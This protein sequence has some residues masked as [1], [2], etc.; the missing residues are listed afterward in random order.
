MN[1]KIVPYLVIIL[2]STIVFSQTDINQKLEQLDLKTAGIEDIIKLF[3]EPQ[4]YS[5][6][7]QPL[8]KDELPDVYLAAYPNGLIFL[9]NNGKISEI[10]HEGPTGYRYKN[11]LEVGSSLETALEVLGQP[12]QTLTGQKNKYT[13][14]VLYKDIDG[15]KGS[16]YYQRSEQNIR[17]FFRNYKVAALYITNP[18]KNNSGGFKRGQT[19]SKVDH[20]DD[21]RWKDLSKI[22]TLEKD[23]VRSLRF[24]QDTVWPKQEVGT[25]T[26]D[27]FAD[28]VLHAAM[29]PG[30]GVRKLHKM[31][32]T[33][34]GV[35]VAIID[36]PTYLIHSEFAGKIVEYYDTG[37][38]TDESS[39]HGPSVV[40]LLVGENCG[41]A[42]G[43]RVYYAA[44]P[45]W[46]KDSAYYA[47]A[48]DWIIDQNHQL[49]IG[50]KIRVVSVSACP[51][52][53]GSPFEK[54][55]AMWDKACAQ[56][57]T[58]GI[59][60]LDCTDSD[61]G[62]VVPAHFTRT[63]N[64]NPVSCCPGFPSNNKAR[65]IFRESL[66]VPTCPRTT[67]EDRGKETCRYVYWGQGGLSWAI[68]YAAG[69][70]AMGWQV[71]PEATP[72]QMKE[73]LFQSAYTN[74]DGA[75]IIN[76]PRFINY[77]KKAQKTNNP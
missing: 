53:Q 76:P 35:N 28:K 59:M 5:W 32:I 26:I 13:D 22:Q 62:F 37:C 18:Y 47:K 8:H 30:L 58:M 50:Q 77:V 44:A 43:A 64:E 15:S 34:K 36:Q 39:M 16:C 54:N 14:G 42:P 1:R 60:I 4:S 20:Y 74:K 41:T 38:E 73:L 52:G 71:W 63:A 31:G 61:R 23:L 49:P 48:L 55:N 25:K 27:W 2:I 66:Y 11:K 7:M 9:M 45:S 21:V 67:A 46:K 12:T 65:M 33:G 40:S 19:L 24:N 29:N 72:E 70:L 69:V 6:K 3:G 17:L 68:P 56:A 57:K 75:K 51:S 10:R